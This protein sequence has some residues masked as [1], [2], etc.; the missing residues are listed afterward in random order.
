MTKKKLVIIVIILLTT[1]LLFSYTAWQTKVKNDK[2]IDG[3]KLNIIRNFENINL[4]SFKDPDYNV[5]K[6][7]T[8]NSI[9]R[10]EESA[11]TLRS[12]E[13]LTGDEYLI[14]GSVLGTMENLNEVLFQ[15]QKYYDE[16]KPF[17]LNFCSDVFIED[18]EDIEQELIMYKDIIKFIEKPRADWNTLL[19]EWDRDNLSFCDRRL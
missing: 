4:D 13:R 10:I 18:N 12:S 7:N 11:K 9:T 14:N 16:E 15:I 2:V 1:N 6:H 3:H 5:Y 19:E 8:M 17:T